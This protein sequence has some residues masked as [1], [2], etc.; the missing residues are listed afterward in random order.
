MAEITETPFIKQWHV[1]VPTPQ[2]KKG[3][4]Q[5]C[6]QKTR[7][8]RLEAPV[9]TKKKNKIKKLQ[10]QIHKQQKCMF[11]FISQLSDLQ[12]K[13]IHSIFDH[14]FLKLGFCHLNFCLHKVTH[15]FFLPE[16]HLLP[17]F[18]IDSMVSW[19]EIPCHWHKHVLLHVLPL[20]N[21]IFI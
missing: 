17:S 19:L 7:K 12:K 9:T 14:I 10:L 6:K 3:E 18:N 16:I 20:E 15:I 21:Y 11:P 4:G 1:H 8:N 2:T 13:A 5:V